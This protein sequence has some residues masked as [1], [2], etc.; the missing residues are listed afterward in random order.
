MLSKKL[1]KKLMNDT[2]IQIDIVLRNHDINNF[3]LLHLT[4]IHEKLI[5]H[6]LLHSRARGVNRDWN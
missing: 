3:L 4:K 1:P 2:D 5:K 6:Y